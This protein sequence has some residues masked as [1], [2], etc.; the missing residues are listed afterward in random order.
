M[1]VP[2]DDDVPSRAGGGGPAAAS[3]PCSVTPSTGS[4]PL[5]SHEQA[6]QSLAHS[7]LLKTG[8]GLV[9]PAGLLQLRQPPPWWRE[10][11]WRGDAAATVVTAAAAAQSSATAGPT[12]HLEVTASATTTADGMSTIAMQAN[13]DT[14]RS[15]TKSTIQSST[16]SEA[17]PLPSFP[18]PPRSVALQTS[19][20]TLPTPDHEQQPY[21]QLGIKHPLVSKLIRHL[22]DS[23]HQLAMDSFS[24]VVRTIQAGDTSAEIP[25]G[26][27]K[28]LFRLICP[29]SPFDAYRVLSYY[30]TLTTTVEYEHG[31]GDGDIS[32]YAKLYERACDAIRHLDPKRHSKDA[33][34][35]LVRSILATV[36]R[37]DRFGQELCLPTLVSALVEQKSFSLG[38]SFAGPVYRHLM[39]QPGLCD[40]PGGFWVH[41]L[42]HSRYNRQLDLP[43]DDV[44]TRMVDAGRRPQP[45]VVLSALDNLFPFTNTVAVTKMLQAILRLQQQIV[46]INKN[47]SSD[48]ENGDQYYV[49]MGTLEMIGAAAASQGQSDVNL[50]IWDMLDILGYQ[51]TVGVYENT[52]AAFAMNTFTYREAFTVL[53]EME[54]RGFKPSRALLRTFSTHLRYVG[55]LSTS[56]LGTFFR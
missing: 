5:V 51:P 6:L 55:E 12:V 7:L 24:E 14:I 1:V 15:Y 44:M 37:F 35:K 9:Q 56:Q 8:S 46:E 41:L 42:S 10:P 4:W 2:A 49:D 21:P 53:V 3:D 13:S 30:V 48:G 23:N 43:F 45:D 17:E 28:A 39:E 29:H 31:G 11:P 19:P 32:V 47:G 20:S 38:Q 27:V 40:L 25:P 22:H 52:V 18:S 33:C 36:Q 34:H 54:D 50:L 16:L 26:I